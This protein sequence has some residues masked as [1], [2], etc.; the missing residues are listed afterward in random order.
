M[1]V[2][3]VIHG[4]LHLGALGVVED[5][6]FLLALGVVGHVEVLVLVEERLQNAVVADAL[7]AHL[8]ELGQILLHHLH[9]SENLLR[10]DCELGYHVVVPLFI[11]EVVVALLH[12]GNVAKRLDQFT[13]GR[14]D[15]SIKHLLQ[16]TA[17]R[18]SKH[19]ELL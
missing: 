10:V 6:E 17:T 8:A 19:L 11:C 13:S 4:L 5:E 18:S 9:L 15:K 1:V 14:S 7:E 2:D 12:I 3:H 16:V